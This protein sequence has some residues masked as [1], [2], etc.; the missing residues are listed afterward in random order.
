[1]AR[2]LIIASLFVSALLCAEQAVTYEFPQGRISESTF[3]MQTTN[4]QYIGGYQANDEK[5]LL[6]LSGSEAFEGAPGK[7][8]LWKN[9]QG[10]IT[11][12]SAPGVLSATTMMKGQTQI[13]VLG[14][15]SQV[16][17]FPSHFSFD[18]DKEM[19]CKI[20]LCGKAVPYRGGYVPL[21]LDTGKDRNGHVWLW[22]SNNLPWQR[23]KVTVVQLIP[24]NLAGGDDCI[25]S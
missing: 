5:W 13:Y 3:L 21:V 9:Y 25:V 11:L 8:L 19:N 20:E 1:M 14:L 6:G 12:D 24:R 23:V 17:N 2:I 15:N 16:T 7:C 18:C 4:G 22:P 10:T